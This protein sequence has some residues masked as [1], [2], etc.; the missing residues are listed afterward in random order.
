MFV[1][2]EAIIWRARGLLTYRHI[3]SSQSQFSWKEFLDRVL[4][5][6]VNQI[7]HPSKPL[8]KNVI[9]TIGVQME[10]HAINFRVIE[11]F[12]GSFKKPVQNIHVLNNKQLNKPN[13][14]CAQRTGRGIIF[15]DFQYV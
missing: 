10:K 12:A 2:F 5:K 4:F 9:S 8:R 3:T 14:S 7:I 6:P 11:Y 1:S 13:L 15:F